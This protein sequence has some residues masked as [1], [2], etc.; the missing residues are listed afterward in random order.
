MS[1]SQLLAIARGMTAARLSVGT[2]GN[3]SLRLDADQFLVTPSGL[4]PERCRVEDI[5]RVR[6]DG[7][8]VGPLA[9]SSEW[10]MHRD[11]YRARPEI[12]AILHAHAPFAT[13]LACHRQAIPPF[14]Y[15]IARFGGDSIR[16]GAYATFGTQ[17]LSDATVAALTNRSA[18]LMANHG[19]IVL[20]ESADTLLDRAIEFEM[21]CEHY[22]RARTLGEPALLDAT[23]MRE[24]LERFDRYGRPQ[25][26]SSSD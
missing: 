14:H 7:S 21:L 23:Q 5:A 25:A 3:V 2:A 26:G 16:C 1:A 4:A 18:C 13:A 20:S 19:M 9:P 17:A 12:G 11:I 10:R 15:M 8:A 22:W 6:A 24:A